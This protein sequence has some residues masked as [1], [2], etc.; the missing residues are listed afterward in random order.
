MPFK[1][2]QSGNTAQQF[3]PGKSGNPSGRKSGTKNWSSI[4]QKL[5]ANED[6]ANKV[7]AKKP[8]WW[9]NLPNKN[10]AEIIVAA[11]AIAAAGGEIAAA[12]WLRKTG[13]GNTGKYVPDHDP[14]PAFSP[15]PRLKIILPVKIVEEVVTSS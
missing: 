14:E 13:Y 4:I 9:N 7:I 15:T 3:K 12:E 5:L 6:F 8:S 2:G 10:L 1:P 11:M